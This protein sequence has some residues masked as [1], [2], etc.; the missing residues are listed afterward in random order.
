MKEGIL[1]RFQLC[2]LVLGLRCFSSVFITGLFFVCEKGVQ[3][4]HIKKSC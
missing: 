1:L 3:N 2:L 4:I